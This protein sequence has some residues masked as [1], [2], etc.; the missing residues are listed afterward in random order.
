MRYAVGIDERA[1]RELSELP[2]DTRTRVRARI[3]SLA[4]PERYEAAGQRERG[5]LEHPI[6]FV[7]CS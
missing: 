6:V 1:L 7:A 5:T 2:Q 4:Q 3:R